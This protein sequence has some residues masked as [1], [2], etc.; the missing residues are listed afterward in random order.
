MLSCVYGDFLEQ[1]WCVWNVRPEYADSN[2][3]V[4]ESC[5]T[6]V[7]ELVS[8]SWWRF[9]L[10]GKFRNKGQTKGG[11]EKNTH[12][13][14]NARRAVSNLTSRGDTKSMCD[15]SHSNFVSRGVDMGASAPCWTIYIE[16]SGIGL[17]SE[18]LFA[19]RLATVCWR[20]PM[21]LLVR[22][23]PPFFYCCGMK[24]FLS[25]DF[26]FQTTPVFGAK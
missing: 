20:I 15:H 4:C 13:S 23:T 2:F 14:K 25:W 6:V 18:A 12:I 3:I 11:R 19:G 1:I 10:G 7:I 21:Y 17:W 22:P 9:F 5:Q 26:I 24:N 16:N 8:E